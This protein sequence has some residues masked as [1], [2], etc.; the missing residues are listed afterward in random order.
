MIVE[1]DLALGIDLGTRVHEKGNDETVK[2]CCMERRSLT[3]WNQIPGTGLKRQRLTQNF[4]ENENKDHADIEPGLLGCS[5]DTCVT[6]NTD[7]KTI[8]HVISS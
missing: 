2:T 5:A 4:S 8:H 1:Y 6:D 3:N 7:G